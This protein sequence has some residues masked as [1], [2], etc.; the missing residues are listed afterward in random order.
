MG[1]TRTE[2]FLLASAFAGLTIEIL[3]FAH[4]FGNRWFI[5]VSIATPLVAFPTIWSI[6]MGSNRRLVVCLIIV[7]ACF[8]Q[9]LYPLYALG[10][11]YVPPRDAPYQMQIV[12][13]ILKNNSIPFGEGTGFAYSYSFYPLMD[14]L[15]ASVAMITSA[16]SMLVLKLSPLLYVVIPLAIYLLSKQVF[17]SEKAAQIAATIFIF[18]PRSYPAPAW[19]YFGLF[20][21]VLLLFS[22]LSSA[23]REK[24]TRT[25]YTLLAI[26]SLFAITAG[27]HMTLYITLLL[28]LFTCVASII[29]Q[30][31]IR[32]KLQRIPDY[33]SVLAFVIGF[34]WL[35]YVAY[36]D[37]IVHK[38][39]V[40]QWLSFRP[41]ENSFPLFNPSYGI[42]EEVWTLASFSSIILIGLFGFLVYVRGKYDKIFITS[43]LY[44]SF[45]FLFLILSR[46]IGVLQEDL[47]YRG[48][49]YL[50]IP[51]SGLAGYFI[52]SRLEA[53]PKIE[54]VYQQSGDA[55]SYLRKNRRKLLVLL[56]VALFISY[57]VAAIDVMPRVYYDFNYEEETNVQ[58]VFRG[59]GERLFSSV[60]WYNNYSTLAD[61]A[62]ADSAIR[63]LAGHF[64]G[65]ASSV[66]LYYDVYSNLTIVDQFESFAVKHDIAYVFVDQLLSVYDQSPGPKEII[67][68]VDV[69]YL[70]HLR[71]NQNLN[72][73]YDN[74]LVQI[75]AL[76]TE[77]HG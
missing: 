10:F 17:K 37:F 72:C 29:P 24:N 73:I 50:F 26:L 11:D 9:C 5:L 63:D 32:I 43:S 70:N 68:K 7:A 34:S 44:F 57:A 49:M 35:M 48:F 52:I 19:R 39:I 12:N 56:F 66:R 77:P 41:L 36:P 38:L 65:S 45:L 71:E 16:D 55:L 30:T 14:T 1:L 2:V 31:L 22:V 61:I 60:E 64:N 75:M 25:G 74:G 58:S 46:N 6:L 42:A 4:L 3:Y 33:L 18:N 21:L 13:A 59:Y 54:I 76:R 28:I 15:L 51:V 40:E 67:Q 8:V 69:K 20:Y 47:S 62:A 53:L 27:H 23:N